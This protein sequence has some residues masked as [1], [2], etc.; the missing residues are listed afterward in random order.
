MIGW[1]TKRLPWALLA[2]MLVMVAAHL[3]TT[4]LILRSPGIDIV[5]AYGFSNLLVI[6]SFVPLVA[7][8]ALIAARRPDNSFG[9]LLIGI[10]FIW[11]TYAFLDMYSVYAFGVRDGE[12]FGSQF[13]MWAGNWMFYPALCLVVAFVPLLFPS[14]HLPTGR[15]RIVFWMALIGTLCASI[16]FAFEPTTFETDALPDDSGIPNPY[17][18]NAWVA[19]ILFAIGFPLSISAGVAA[20]VFIVWR[21]RRARGVE[22]Q[23][24]KWVAYVGALAAAIFGVN[25]MLFMFELEIA[26]TIWVLQVLSF[27]AF[28]IAAG[29]AIVRHRLFD[30]DLL[31]R[32][33]LVYGLLTVSLVGAYLVLILVSQGVVQAISGQRSD[34]TTAISTLGVAALFRPFLTRIRAL[35]DR[36]FYRRKYDAARLLE[37]FSARLRDQLDLAMLSAEISAVVDETMRPAHV[38]LWLRPP[39]PR[40]PMA[41]NPAP[42][43]RERT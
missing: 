11:E 12:I 8:G 36:R 13:A 37:S 28:P 16:G 20:G 2:L 6:P 7:L 26:P 4:W 18:F 10:G 3:L 43:L 30:I 41:S 34:L 31:I 17:A 24:L 1:V 25:T 35:V 38:S 29:I 22:R 27:A 23:Q 40:Q 9:W 19:D 42:A 32:R 21:L 33:T 39:A 14:G 15:W 5:R